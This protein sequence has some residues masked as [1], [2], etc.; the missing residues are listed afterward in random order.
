SGGLVMVSPQESDSIN[1]GFT[2]EAQSS[3]EFGSVSFYYS[4]GNTGSGTSIGTAQKIS[5]G[6]GWRYVLDWDNL[7][8]SGNWRVFARASNGTTSTRIPVVVP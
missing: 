7:P 5:S 1:S 8:S 6:G 3:T 2:L 4:S